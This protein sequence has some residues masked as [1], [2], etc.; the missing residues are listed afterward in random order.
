[1]G[2]FGE[3]GDTETDRTTAV[4]AKVEA[5]VIIKIVGLREFTVDHQFEIVADAAA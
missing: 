4:I 5:E 2:A 1:M 3:F